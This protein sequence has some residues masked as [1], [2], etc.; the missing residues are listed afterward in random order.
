[1][2]IILVLLNCTVMFILIIIDLHWSHARY[3]SKWN[4]DW[5]GE[6]K[7]PPPHKSLP[8]PGSQNWNTTMFNQIYI[9]LCQN[10]VIPQCSMF[11]YCFLKMP[12]KCPKTPSFRISTFIFFGRVY[13]KLAQKYAKAAIP[14]CSVFDPPAYTQITKCLNFVLLHTLLSLFTFF[15]FFLF[16]LSVIL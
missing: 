14:N 7:L 3:C 9:F 8:H 2:I 10:I 4:L 12:H 11:S 13:M 16:Y 5:G 15:L 1:M 6:N